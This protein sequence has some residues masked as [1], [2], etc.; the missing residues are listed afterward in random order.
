[1]TELKAEEKKLLN[2]AVAKIKNKKIKDI[3]F[4][5]QSILKA[6]DE[7]MYK[8]RITRILPL[9]ILRLQIL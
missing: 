4:V 2:I 7:F 6:V 8:R 1:M 3:L 5:Q 9:M